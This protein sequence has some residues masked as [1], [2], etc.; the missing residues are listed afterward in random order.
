MAAYDVDPVPST[1]NKHLGWQTAGAGLVGLPW[2]SVNW[3]C[4]YDSVLTVLW[5]LFSDSPPEWSQNL[6]PG[7]EL[8]AFVRSAF[9]TITAPAV[10]LVTFR[11]QFRDLLHAL[12][13]VRFPRFGQ[14]M[15]AVADIL[16]MLLLS[17]VPFGNSSSVCPECATSSDVSIDACASY[18]WTVPSACWSAYCS[19][20]ASV[21]ASEYIAA[22]LDGCFTRPCLT[23][24]AEC[25]I[26]TTLFFPPP[27]IVIDAAGGSVSPQDQVML[28][29][30]G[31]P[32]LMRLRGVIYHGAN[33]FTA[34]FLDHAGVVWYHDGAS[35]T[36]G[37]VR[38]ERSVRGE[39]PME[40][41]RSRGAC[42]YIY[43]PS[44]N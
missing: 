19:G 37:C 10:Q 5:N 14:E 34:R 16:S 33:H 30:T 20:K 42:H 22:L 36:T 21:S 18:M 35:Q 38:E 41:A 8:M 24:R 29:V 28:T 17:A 32:Y 6:A 31:Q 25:H 11:E 12:A 27:M 43:V 26:R 44:G 13:P 1:S 39:L 3:S 40:T 9:T 15:T 23:C 2:D 7:N 4:A